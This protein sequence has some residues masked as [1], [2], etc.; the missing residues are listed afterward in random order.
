[1]KKIMLGAA[2]VGFSA[3]AS[4]GGAERELQKAINQ[5]GYA[6]P[7]VTQVFLSGKY[8]GSLMFSVACNGGQTYMVKVNSDGTGNVL[9]C[10]LMEKFG[11]KCF[12][13]L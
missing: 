8:N 3:M 11:S 4:A 12:Q 13:K 9:P 6:C 1:M 5:V 2:L 7:S 10:R